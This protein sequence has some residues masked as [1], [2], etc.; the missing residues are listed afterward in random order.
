[1]NEV[2]DVA[3]VTQSEVVLTYPCDRFRTETAKFI[4][5]VTMRFERIRSCI[6]LMLLKMVSYLGLSVIRTVEWGWI[7]CTASTPPRTAQDS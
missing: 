1:M 3:V 4:D 7:V 2:R 5:V 6:I